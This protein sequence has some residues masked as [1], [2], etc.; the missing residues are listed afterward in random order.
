MS[1]ETGR[2]RAERAMAQAA[3]W[4]KNNSFSRHAIEADEG[5]ARAR[6]E[7]REGGA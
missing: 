2:A 6:E 4:W 7:R 1:G 3:A 5:L